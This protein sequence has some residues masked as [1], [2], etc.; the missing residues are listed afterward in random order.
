MQDK[1]CSLYVGRRQTVR[2]LP[3]EGMVW[4]NDT[5]ADAGS[6]RCLV[7][8]AGPVFVGD[9]TFAAHVSLMQIA[10]YIMDFLYRD[11]WIVISL[12]IS[13]QTPMVQMLDSMWT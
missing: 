8:H 9:E 1:A 12:R 10:S 2:P 3:S 11:D 6:A 4:R 5:F 13:A 7:N